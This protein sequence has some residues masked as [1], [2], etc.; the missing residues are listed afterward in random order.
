MTSTGL[1]T[2][3]VEDVLHIIHQDGFEPDVCPDRGEDACG[4]ILLASDVPVRIAD[5]HHERVVGLQRQRSLVRSVDI[6]IV[7]V[8][9]PT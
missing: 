9:R 4:G 3:A 6:A 8:V 5:V 1:R 2:S 7:E